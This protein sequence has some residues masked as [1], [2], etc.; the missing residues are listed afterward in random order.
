[1]WI[2]HGASQSVNGYGKRAKYL[3]VKTEMMFRRSD[4]A[5]TCGVKF[6]VVNRFFGRAPGPF[7][8]PKSFILPGGSAEM[9]CLDTGLGQK[10]NRLPH[11][12]I[13]APKLLHPLIGRA[14]FI[15][16]A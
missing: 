12:Q 13:I 6:E 9:Q 15:D 16:G 11:R 4:P 1:M 2:N 14:K 3:G 8:T 5:V 7:K 10:F